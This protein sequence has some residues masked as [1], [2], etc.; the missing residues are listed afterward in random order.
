MVPCL[1]GIA[2]IYGRYIRK[3]T[4]IL[5][6]QLADISKTAEER[7]SNIK[8]VQIFCKE[9]EELQR[10]DKLLMDT[11]KLSYKEAI[12]K[13]TF[14]GMVINPLYRYIQVKFIGNMI[15]V[16]VLFLFF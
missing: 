3:I 6:D 11:L 13:A 16:V 8:T 12:A 2:I 14:F 15:F 1:A 7:L 5:L 10:Y 4:R 9:N